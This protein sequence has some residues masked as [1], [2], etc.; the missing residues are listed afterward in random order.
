MEK[1]QEKTSKDL[2]GFHKVRI[3]S[4]VFVAKKISRIQNTP[5]MPMT[6][7]MMMI[8]SSSEWFCA[9]K[10]GHLAPNLPTLHQLHKP[11]W[12][13]NNDISDNSPHKNQSSPVELAK[14]YVCHQLPCVCLG[15]R[16]GLKIGAVKK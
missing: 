3:E 2:N 8:L 15:V 16:K 5:S 11:V 6:V 7:K 10:I 14:Y 9:H 1:F 12:P 4:K 13:Q